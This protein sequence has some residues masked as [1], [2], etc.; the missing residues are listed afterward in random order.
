[1]GVLSIEVVIVVIVKMI[2]CLVIFFVVGFLGLLSRVGVL[3]VSIYIL[4]FVCKCKKS[5]LSDRQQVIAF[6]VRLL[7][8]SIPN[9][10]FFV[11]LFAFLFLSGILGNRSRYPNLF[12]ACAATQFP[13]RLRLRALPVYQ[14][15]GRGA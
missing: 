5:A 11:F 8:V 13:T 15:N 3:L 14:D 4:L 1:M 12:V 10:A 9:T 6:S 7:T 2:V